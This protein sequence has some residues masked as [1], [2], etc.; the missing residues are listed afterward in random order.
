ME[1]FRK[2]EKGGAGWWLRIGCI[3]L[4]LSLRCLRCRWLASLHSREQFSDGGV[5]YLNGYF[6]CGLART[7]RVTDSHRQ[8]ENHLLIRKD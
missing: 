6:S 1:G 7:F 2:G 4:F 5:E 8:W 3:L